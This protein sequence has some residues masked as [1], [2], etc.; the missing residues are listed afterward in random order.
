MDDLKKE[1]KE[2]TMEAGSENRNTD[3]NVGHNSEA[4][5]TENQYRYVSA[6]SSGR[7]VIS[8]ERSDP[9]CIRFESSR[10]AVMPY[11]FKNCVNILNVQSNRGI[12][13]IGEGAFENCIGLEIVS[14]Y[15]SDLTSI[16]ENAFKGCINLTTVR[17]SSHIHTISR[18]A[19]KDCIRL[20]SIYFPQSLDRI[21]EGAFM[22][23]KSIS[24][25]N[26]PVSLNEVS[27]YA[28]KNCTVLSKLSIPTRV[29]V[30]DKG[31]FQ[32]CN[33]LT[34]INIK[35]SANEINIKKGAFA[36][37]RNIDAIV[38]KRV[39][40]E[41]GERTFRLTKCALD[42]KRVCNRTGL[43]LDRALLFIPR[44]CKDNYGYL[45][46]N[47]NIFDE[48][49]NNQD[50]ISNTNE[51]Q[52]ILCEKKE[53][54]NSAVIDAF[55]RRGIVHC[56]FD[57]S[58]FGDN[59]ISSDVKKDDAASEKYSA[60]DTLS[61][62][63]QNSKV[64]S[65]KDIPSDIKLNND[66]VP[67]EHSE[68]CGHSCLPKE[69]AADTPASSA[70]D[71]IICLPSNKPE[72]KNGD[73]NSG[74]FISIFPKN[75]NP[76]NKAPVDCSTQNSCQLSGIN[77]PNVSSICPKL[78]L[79]CN[80]KLIYSN[81]LLAQ[82]SYNIAAAEKTNINSESAVL[83]SQ[84]KTNRMVSES[85]SSDRDSLTADGTY[86]NNKHRAVLFNT[87][88]R[89]VLNVQC[90]NA[91]A[92]ASSISQSSSY[93]EVKAIFNNIY[94]DRLNTSAEMCGNDGSYNKPDNT[95]KRENI[96]GQNCF[97]SIN[98]MLK[99]NTCGYRCKVD[100]FLKFVEASNPNLHMTAIGKKTSSFNYTANSVKNSASETKI[101]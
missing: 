44:M 70:A 101:F 18:Y 37:C 51:Y 15:K 93:D 61:D 45:C 5:F 49:V 12:E 7:Y 59:Y 66:N 83:F 29:K 36:G 56:K 88:D 80:P 40:G 94:P 89:P 46:L 76:L 26:L 14:L 10:K 23:C 100:S 32:N 99:Q 13:N 81:Y 69:P 64:I 43:D 30:L 16:G 65:N 28:F 91:N 31:T 21:S 58:I 39:K 9:I 33:K 98:D 47:V 92:D 79:L 87:P 62:T 48:Y 41:H 72:D 27:K 63:N 67:P 75:M 52:G 84:L 78:G 42:R 60:A 11:E 22:N 97:Y 53:N 95:F 19:F 4:P 57:G 50:D 68:G 38:V 35:G 25:L 34:T 74:A 8:S 82:D 54:R 86:N 85:A 96:G 20:K 17:L 73:S 90:A 2:I 6:D 77:T 24:D 71:S 3:Q 1:L 55:S